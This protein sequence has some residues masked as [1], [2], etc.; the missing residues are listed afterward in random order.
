MGG[1]SFQLDAVP[2]LAEREN[3]NFENLPET[4][5][6]IK[7]FRRRLNIQ[8]LAECCWP[9]PINGLR[10]SLHQSASL[11]FKTD[12][13]SHPILHDGRALPV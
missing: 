5:A 11:S 2:Y 9:K 13:R 3:T 7:E 8:F 12:S 10:M 6:I 1:Y 4:Q